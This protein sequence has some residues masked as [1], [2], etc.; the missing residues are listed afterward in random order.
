M[1]PCG[2]VTCGSV[3][4]VGSTPDEM[5]LVRIRTRPKVITLSS[6][7]CNTFNFRRV[8]D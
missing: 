3:Q 6:I 8:R 2:S 5:T 4:I 1:M 7:V